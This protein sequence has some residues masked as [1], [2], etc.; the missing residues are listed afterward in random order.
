MPAAQKLEGRLSYTAGFGSFYSP[1][2]LLPPWGLSTLALDENSCPLRDL[3][4]P[5]SGSLPGECRTQLLCLLCSGQSVVSLPASEESVPVSSASATSPT[6]T[7]PSHP[8]PPGE[9]RPL[10]PN[11]HPVLGQPAA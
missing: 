7:G 4:L 11:P 9:P 8:R 5:L 3:T 10:G 2:P 1:M 6:P